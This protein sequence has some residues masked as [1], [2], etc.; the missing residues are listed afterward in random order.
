MT[1][2]HLEW[3][4][5]PA[6]FVPVG[7]ECCDCGLKMTAGEFAILNEIRKLQKNQVG[8]SQLGGIWRD[9]IKKILDP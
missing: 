6:G 1:C 4:G 9:D 3:I 2:E 8:K 5:R 7:W